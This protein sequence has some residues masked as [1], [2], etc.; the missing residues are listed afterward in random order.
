MEVWVNSREG[1]H[2][3]GKQEILEVHDEYVKASGF[4][5]AC[6]PLS[7]NVTGSIFIDML[8]GIF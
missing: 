8:G 7:K 1:Y 5:D 6:I 2:V 3:H 4:P